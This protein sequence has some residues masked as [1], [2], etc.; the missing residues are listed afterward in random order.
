MLNTWCEVQRPPHQRGSF[1]ETGGISALRI[2]VGLEGFG[3]QVHR[4]HASDDSSVDQGRGW[5]QLSVTRP[6]GYLGSEERVGAVREPTRSHGDP[7]F[8]M[9]IVSR[10]PLGVS[11][12]NLEG[13]GLLRV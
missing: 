5:S 2:P 10:D 4:P 6:S 1:F 7:L 3:C 13:E 12:E 9:S 8:S 11:R